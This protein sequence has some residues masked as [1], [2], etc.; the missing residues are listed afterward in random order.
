MVGLLLEFS[1]GSY[2]ISCIQAI[3]N[4]ILIMF[5]DTQIMLFYNGLCTDTKTVHFSVMSGLAH[6]CMSIPEES[7]GGSL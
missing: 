3:K 2:C 4:T 1:I 5:A 6:I 7:F